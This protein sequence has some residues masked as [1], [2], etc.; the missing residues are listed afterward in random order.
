MTL[1]ST[2]I[3]LFIITVMGMVFANLILK[4][5]SSLPNALHDVAVEPPQS[6]EKVDLI[7][8]HGQIVNLARFKGKWSFLFI[9]FTHCD[10]ICAPALAQMAL[11]KKDILKQ[12][13]Y[14]T[15]PPAFV[16]VSVDPKR[17]TPAHL[18]NY[19]LN[20]DADFIGMTGQE[21]AVLDFEQ[22][23]KAF[24]RV[25]EDKRKPQGY[26]I[27]HSGEIYLIDPAA[28]LTAKFQPPLDPEQVIIQFDL[29]VKHYAAAKT[30]AKTQTGTGL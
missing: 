18:A 19:L 14:Q 21:A 12:A 1:R 25:R 26:D 4:S 2:L 30:E 22:R 20:F 5:N 7:D 28:R 17:D 29:F 10:H 15:A 23:L 8:H 11:L 27:D 16:F 24:H 9:G 3:G 6:L 13:V